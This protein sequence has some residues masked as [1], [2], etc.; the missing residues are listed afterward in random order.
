MRPISIPVSAVAGRDDVQL[1]S[2]SL[3]CLSLL[4]VISELIYSA[5]DCI[6]MDG[7]LGDI[8]LR[9]IL[10]DKKVLNQLF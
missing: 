7:F 1:W 5:L 3:A 10:D 4:F 8:N 6:V 9:D 2:Q